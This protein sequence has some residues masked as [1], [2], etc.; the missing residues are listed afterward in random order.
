[1]PN[2]PLIQLNRS[3]GLPQIRRTKRTFG[4][5][6]SLT[7]PSIKRRLERRKNKERRQQQVRVILNRRNQDRRRKKIPAHASSANL[8]VTIGEHI[9]ITA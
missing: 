8:S 7:S 1:M 3:A 5:G 2:I 4:G 9:N 6:D